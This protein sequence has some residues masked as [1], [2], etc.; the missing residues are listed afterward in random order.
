MV[1][2]PGVYDM[3][4]YQNQDWS[5]NVGWRINEFQV[6]VSTYTALLLVK[7][8]AVSTQNVVVLSTENGRIDRSSLPGWF[9]LRLDAATTMAL[10]TNR[11]IY[12]MSV[13]DGV[14]S[15]PIMRG[16]FVVRGGLT[17][18]ESA[19]VKAPLRDVVYG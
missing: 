2:Q 13:N 11:F 12:D 5:L 19:S 18:D 1:F 17:D 8:S 15:W 16:R 3:F 4:V 6:D 7:Q 10:P 14:T 9:V